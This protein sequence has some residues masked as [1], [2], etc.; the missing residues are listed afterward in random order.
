M[1]YFT[2]EDKELLME[3]QYHFPL[4]ERP[5]LLISEKIGL[6]E[7]DVVN[8]IKYY[9]DHEVVK[10]VGMYINYRSKGMTAALV[11][12]K[13][14]PEK[15]ESFRRK[16]LGIRE[17]THNFVRDHPEYNI[18]FVIKAK[19]KEELDDKIKEL[20]ETSEAHD[21]VILYSKKN[22]K[23][24]VKY[25]IFKGVSW[26]EYEDLPEEIPTANELGISNEFLKYLSLPLPLGPRPFINLASKFG[27]TETE[28]IDMISELK[29]KGVIKD[30]GATLNGEKVGITE[31]AMVLIKAKDL[32]EACYRIAKNVKEATHVVLRESNKP[33]DYL[34]YCMIH[35]RSKEII[36]VV[37]EKVFR[38]A[39]ADDYIKLYSLDNLKPGIVM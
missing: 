25:D 33:W 22:L 38:V 9:V 14:G 11:A 13:L 4:H 5:Y 36:D 6:S 18:W 28:I 7:K 30:Y 34:C 23:L 37:A 1:L 2:V 31:N 21:Y 27:I 29:K 24:V 3:L 8:R 17:I 26:G 10:R 12:A 19:S 32:E 16:A 35:A 39:G 15:I 20:M